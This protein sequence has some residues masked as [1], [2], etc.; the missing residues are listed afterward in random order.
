MW[1]EHVHSINAHLIGN[2]LL[3]KGQVIQLSKIKYC[4]FP[5]EGFI[6]RKRLSQPM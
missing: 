4:K 1:E 5:G 3:K 6:F 2:P